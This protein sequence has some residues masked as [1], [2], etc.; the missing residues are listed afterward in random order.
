MSRKTPTGTKLSARR[1]A[2]LGAGLVAAGL[3]LLVLGWTAPLPLFAKA[4]LFVAGI[5]VL[6]QGLGRVVWAVH[7]TRPDI[8][9]WLCSGWLILL[10]V[11]ALLAPVLPLGEHIDVVK[12]LDAPIYQPP[13]LL[14]EY[15][16]GTNNYGLDMLARSIYGARTSLV[17]ALAAV[18]I[19]TVLGGSLGVIAGFLRSGVDS[20][21]GIFT[22][23]MLAVPPLVMLIALATVLEPKTRNIAFALALLTIPSMIRLAR[24]NTIAFAQREFVLAA[25]AMGATNL[26]I[27]WRELVPNVVLPVF[28]MMV[29]MIS[30]LI[31]A[32]ASLSFLGFGVQ[33][34]AP[35]WGNMIA[36]AEGGTMEEYP[37]IVL[38]PGAF[39]FLTVF[40]FNLLGEKAQKRWDPRS[41]KL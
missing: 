38:V 28:S 34:P 23:A 2:A 32:E 12:A 19:G 31:V 21:V 5:V 1:L 17:I 27:M 8:L 30:V 10:T 24:A 3:A 36:E 20:A 13:R 26:R 16:L 33:A 41:A 22:N 4:A 11:G 6:P 35:T 9:F 14:S 39:L 25:R 37:H 7:G 29:V 40:S 18:A 15:P